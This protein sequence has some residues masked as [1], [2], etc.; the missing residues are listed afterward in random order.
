MFSA[1]NITGLAIGLTCCFLI[2]LYIL[3]ELSFD[4]FQQKGDRIARVVME[5]SFKGGNESIKGAFSSVRVAAVFPKLFPEIESAVK[6]A[7]YDRIIKYEDEFFDEKKVMFADS[8]FFD[9]FSFKLLQG[10]I[11]DALA[12]PYSIVLTESASKKYFGNNNP[13]GKALHVGNDNNLYRISGV[14]QD[15]PSNSQI[16]TDF[17]AS[18]SSLGL[19]REYENSYSD[20]NYVTYFLLKDKN[21]LQPLQDKISAYMKKEMEGKSAIIS[22]FLE[23]FEKIHLY[24]PYDSFVPN[25]N[26]SYIYILAAVAL[27][28][29]VIACFTY[30]NLST[31]RS[32]ERAKEVGVRKLIGAEKKQLFWQF[33]YESV[34]LCLIAVVLSLILS[35]LLLPLFN[36]LV[37]KE[38]G[39]S[40]LF[41]F[42]FIAFSIA[43]AL[44]LSFAAG[45]YPAF[46]FTRFQP[47]KVL[48]GAF[49]NTASG[50]LLRKSLIVFQFCISVFLI[51][52][53][54]VIQRQ[55]HFIQNKKL[56]YD[57]QHVLVLPLDTEMMTN[58][59]AIKQVFKTNS[60]VLS[61][62]RCVRSPVEGGGGYNMRSPSMPRNLEMNVTAN[63][64]DEDFV[65]TVGL[66]LIAGA[67][68]TQQDI[69]DASHIGNWNENIYHFILNESA[70]KQLGWSPQEAINQKMSMGPREGYVR[71]VVKDFNFESL[72]SP[73]KPFVL[74]TEMR[75]RE[76]LVKLNGQHLSQTISF[77]QSKWK[78]LVAHR[79]FEFHFLDEDYDKLYHSEIRLSKVM[80]IFT[81]I[82][83]ALAC[84]GL[85]GLSSYVMQLRI[86]EIGIRKVLG[87]SVASI[88]TLLTKDF[89]Q[90][91]LVAFIIAMPLSWFVMSKWLQDYTYRISIGWEIFLIAIA[92][93]LFITLITVSFQAIKAAIINPVKSLRRE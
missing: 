14:M 34:L 73:I 23:P 17:I 84:F 21:S 65:K 67:D 2:A 6:M 86:K 70:A 26:I 49:K 25:S 5:F 18:F 36:Q 51:I 45:I 90:L 57:R 53:T 80:N 31:A 38:L 55:L 7:Q 40:Q 8:T 63:P 76:L 78:A 39:L 35:A 37:D 16:Q 48:K 81:I 60:N 62:S 13:V 47:I 10:N 68:F 33:I 32:L 87:A 20:A 1:I 46:V 93:S 15:C 42:S 77:L 29:L 74:F 19:S 72:H 12:T 44:G 4:K 54:F 41:S 88:T 85:F 83:T 69:K 28:I 43:V 58:L 92:I 82:G 59:D 22:L 3:H 89:I 75:G 61:V 30:I 24:S 56:G 52:S 66:Q 79:P 71:G 64:V 50:Q 27:L 9:I 11:H 91:V